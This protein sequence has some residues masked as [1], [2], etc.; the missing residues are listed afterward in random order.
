[1]SES[2]VIMDLE[3]MGNDKSKLMQ[4]YSDAMQAIIKRHGG[5]LSDVPVNPDHE[6]HKIQHKLMILNR[7]QV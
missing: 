4:K 1:M 6:Y 7:I 3:A 5:N 2:E